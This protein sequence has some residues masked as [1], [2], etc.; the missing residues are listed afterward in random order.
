M[1]IMRMMSFIKFLL[2]FFLVGYLQTA[3]LPVIHVTR[4]AK[5]VIVD[6]NLD[7]EIWQKSAVEKEFIIYSPKYGDILPYKTAVWISYD[8]KNLYFAMKC[9][10]PEPDKIKTSVTKRDNIWGDDWVGLSL[11]AVGDGQSFYD[12]FVNPSGIQGDILSTRSSGDDSAPDWVWKSAGKIT[13]EG[14]Q[15]EIK[16]PFK[17]IRFKSGKEVDMRIL[18]WRRISRLGISGSWP[19]LKPGKARFENMNTIKYTNIKPV[20]ILEVLPSITYGSSRDRDENRQWLEYDKNTDVGIG[21]KY[22]ITSS[23]TSEVTVNPDFSQ[24]ETDA[25]QVNVNLRY[26]I[27]FTEKRPFF[28][29]SRGVFNIAGTGGDFNMYTAV[30]T[31]RIVDPSWGAKLVGSMGKTSLGI[32]AASDEYPGSPWKDEINPNEGKSA[33]FSILRVKQSLGRGN[34]MGLIYTRR[35]FAERHNQVVGG[36]MKFHLSGPHNFSFSFLNSYTNNSK[37]EDALTGNFLTMQYTYNSKSLYAYGLFD[38]TGK[39]FQMDTAFYNRTGFTKGVVYIGPTFAPNSKKL[40]WIKQINPFFW[41]FLL[42]DMNTGMNDSFMLLG[43]RLNFIKQGFLRVDYHFNNES[44]VN[45]TFHQQKMRVIAEIQLYKWLNLGGSYSFG[46]GIYYDRENPYMGNRRSGSLYL[47][48][49]PNS[50]FRETLGIDYGVFDH[51]DTGEKVYD[52]LILN[53]ETA[54]QFNKYFFIRGNI[55]YDSYYKNVL[56]DFLASF[57]L[58]PGTVVH[59]GYGSLY[60]QRNWQTVNSRPLDH[61]KLIQTRQSFF[62]KASYLWRL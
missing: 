23:L 9:Y 25:F 18:F 48:L 21:L 55:R 50:K 43:L 56:T 49:Q 42:H 40:S 16:L 10:D 11:D 32:L 26:P 12:L 59:V 15:V 28:M 2:L 31:R 20:K 35:D 44:W 36:D 19:A 53:S 3:E 60:E 61:N 51:P 46:D 7:D 39:N 41:G 38:H 37:E 58:I 57:T 30:H 8:S 17:S 34:Y 5:P 14:Y 33:L 24:V 54:Y 62:F 27:L 45:Q 1:K 22:G 29:E 13:E 4:S 52:L 6:G 47:T